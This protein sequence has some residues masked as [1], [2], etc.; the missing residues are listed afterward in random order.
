[1]QRPRDILVTILILNVLANLLIQNAVSTIFDAFDSW[2]LKVKSPFG[3]D[4]DLWGAIAEV[5]C[6]AQPGAG[7]VPRGSGDRLFCEMA[8]PDSRAADEADQF[9]I[10]DLFFLFQGGERFFCRRAA[11]YCEDIGGD[12]GAFAHGVGADQRA[13]DLQNSSV[14]EHMR[15]REEIRCCR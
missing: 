2:P 12:G 1:M 7:G 5:V 13:L 10:A 6:V 8:A 9:F 11:P 4:A 15:P 14:R 3:L